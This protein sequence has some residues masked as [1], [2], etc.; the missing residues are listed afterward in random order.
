MNNEERNFDIVQ[1]DF[2]YVQTVSCL[3]SSH[4]RSQQTGSHRPH[5]GGN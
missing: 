3:L 1:I 4:S 2:K 5:T